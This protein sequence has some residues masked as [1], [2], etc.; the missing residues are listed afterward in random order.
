MESQFLAGINFLHPAFEAV[1]R[2]LRFCSQSKYES[3][4]HNNASVCRQ[5]GGCVTSRYRFRPISVT[6][7][8]RPIRNRSVGN[9]ELI[10]R[11]TERREN[12]EGNLI[13]ARIGRSDRIPEVDRRR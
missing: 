11:R 13:E 1:L 10:W 9:R 8:L 7:N 6:P 5:N 3:S 2:R 4:S 12:E